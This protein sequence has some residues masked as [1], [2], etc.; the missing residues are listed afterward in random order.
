MEKYYKLI[1]F[2]KDYQAEHVADILNGK[3]IFAEIVADKQKDFGSIIT[4]YTI[5]VDV[6]NKEKA[7]DAIANNESIKHY[8]EVKN[9]LEKRCW[10]CGSINV[11]EKKLSKILYLLSIFSFGYVYVAMKAKY[12]CQKCN[13]QWY[14]KYTRTKV[15]NALFVLINCVLI[16]IAI[17]YILYRNID[18]S[19]MGK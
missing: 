15:V 5:V 3:G 16:W 12:I 10:R 7:L 4:Y 1:S 17:A 8:V 6:H 9:I 2:E 13:N 19:I 14:E 18:I 11:E